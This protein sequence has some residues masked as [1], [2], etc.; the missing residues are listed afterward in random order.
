MCVVGGCYCCYLCFCFCFLFKKK[1]KEVLHLFGSGLREKER[2]KERKT[3]QEKII[4]RK[5]KKE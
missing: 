1:I 4:E 3:N 5:R 2:K